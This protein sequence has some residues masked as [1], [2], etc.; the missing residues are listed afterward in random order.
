MSARIQKLTRWVSSYY[1]KPIVLTKIPSDASSRQYFSVKD[2]TALAVCAPTKDNA[3]QAFIDI[4][5]I[6]QKNKLITPKVLASDLAEGFL[7]VTS[8]GDTHYADV[9]TNQNSDAYYQHAMTSLY[10]LQIIPRQACQLIPDYS[11]ALLSFEFKLFQQWFLEA[12]LGLALTAKEQKLL[13]TLEAFFIDNALMQPQV[14]VHRDFHCRNLMVMEKG[15]GLLDFQDAVWG[16]VTY[17]LVSLLKDCYIKWPAQQVES[18]VKHFYEN[19]PNKNLPDFAA[20]LRYF[21]QT[22]AHRHLKCLGVFTRLYIRDGKSGYLG[23][24]PRLLSYLQ[25]APIDSPHWPVF[26]NWFESKLLDL[27]QKKLKTRVYP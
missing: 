22:G 24:I 7:L 21:H 19:H 1:K 16:S 9:L 3:N 20:F 25:E 23:D 10:K 6:L 4:A 26:I 13:D 27:H 15:A 12:W 2:A 14:F 17:D 8:L 5:D 11:S 18:W